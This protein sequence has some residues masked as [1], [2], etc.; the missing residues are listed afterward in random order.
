MGLRL[1]YKYV[2]LEEQ[3]W[4]KQEDGDSEG[5]VDITYRSGNE[6][7]QPPDVQTIRKQMAIVD[8]QPGPNRVLQVPTKDELSRL[9]PGDIVRRTPAQPK[10]LFVGDNL[11]V[12]KSSQ[13][14][15]EPQ[16]ANTT[17]WEELVIDEDGTAILTRQDV[18]PYTGNRFAG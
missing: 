17:S 6:P 5:V 16:E 11:E 3:V 13:S 10:P 7:G 12:F 14:E 9:Q 1:E 18:W 15:K 2:I 8:W 4:T